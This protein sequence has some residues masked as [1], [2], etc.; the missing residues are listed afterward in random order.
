MFASGW[1]LCSLQSM[2]TELEMASIAREG[3]ATN[4]GPL[5]STQASEVEFAHIASARIPLA[6]AWRAGRPGVSSCLAWLS[7]PT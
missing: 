3:R 2:G 6:R 4:L 7:Y 1:Q 5:I